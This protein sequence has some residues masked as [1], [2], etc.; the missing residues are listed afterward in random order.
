MLRDWTDSEKMNKLSVGAERFFVRLIMKADDFGRYYADP[1][2]LRSFL[3]PR[4]V[5]KVKEADISKFLNECQKN[6][7]LSVYEVDAKLYLQI[8]EFGQRLRIMK[9][10][11]PL[12]S[13]RND[14]HLSDTCPQPA[15]DCG[16]PLTSVS[17]ELEVEEKKKL[18]DR[19]EEEGSLLGSGEED[20]TPILLAPQM[21]Q[22]YKTNF[23]DYPVDQNNDFPACVE[24]AAK[25]ASMKGWPA[26]S[27]TNGRQPDVLKEWEAIV[28]F[29]RGDS[30]YSKRSISNLN[31]EF[32][33]LILSKNGTKQRTAAA[34]KNN[35]SGTSNGIDPT[36]IEREGPGEL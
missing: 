18:E 34:G 1:C 26:Q 29:C 14:G 9:S 13:A 22:V 7:V 3:Y 36:L 28:L 11:F 23:P 20:I 5:E 27:I 8:N 16:E 30:W 21:V 17:P 33:T 2:L 15:A 12:P 4:I 35:Y 6:D 32:Q 24:I 31:K 10:K 25:V 19:K